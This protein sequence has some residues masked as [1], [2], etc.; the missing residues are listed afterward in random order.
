VARQSLNSLPPRIQEKITPYLPL[1]YFGAQ[2][3][4]F[5]FFYRPLSQKNNNFG[6]YLHRTGGYKVFDVLHRASAQSPAL[7]AY[8][9]GYIT[10]YAADV[11][12]HPYVYA[13]SK[14]STWTHTRIESA[15]DFA[16][17]KQYSK[18]AKEDFKRYFKPC[19]SNANKGE[20]FTLYQDVA[21]TCGLPP[22]IKP[23]FHRAISYFNA[24]LP[25]SFTLLT[26]ERH[27]LM[28]AVFGEE[29]S[30]KVSSLFLSICV[31]AR[32]LTR[33]F[34]HTL[35][36]AAPLPKIFFDKSFLTGKPIN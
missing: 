8:A 22:L 13:F 15:L 20:L 32:M 14:K 26:Q 29:Y 33:E 9:A 3:A 11:I 24:Y 25:L 16:Y 17:G 5:C 18:L 31:R 23:A 6:S 19:L 12:L 30:Q 34:L 27:S 35:E 7:F 2:G 1:Y 36:T 4:D 21:K 10:H 28:L